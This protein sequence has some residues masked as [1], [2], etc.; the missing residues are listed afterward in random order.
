MLLTI[1]R[2]IKIRHEHDEQRNRWISH[3]KSC[4]VLFPSFPIP[5]LHSFTTNHEH[6]F[7]FMTSYFDMFEQYCKIIMKHDHVISV[8]LLA[9][10][11]ESYLSLE[12]LIQM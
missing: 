5:S 11:I 7:Y 12:Q 3:V 6:I 10:F 8:N 9:A 2:C 1:F 4:T